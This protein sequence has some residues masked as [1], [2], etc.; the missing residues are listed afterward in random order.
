[1]S[2]ANEYEYNIYFISI[3]DKNTTYIKYILKVP[4]ILLCRELAMT[5]HHVQQQQIPTA[6]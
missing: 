4:P 2:L 1:L 6:L 5:F 3:R